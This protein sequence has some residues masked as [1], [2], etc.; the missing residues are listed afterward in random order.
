M[1]EDNT[2]SVFKKLAKKNEFELKNALIEP[3]HKEFPFGKNG[4]CA[5]IGGMGKG[6]SYQYLKLAHKQQDIFNQ[7]FFETVVICSTSG[8]FDK[9]VKSYKPAIEKSNLISVKDDELLEWLSAYKQKILL[10]NTIM[11]YVRNKFK[12]PSE[13]MIKIINEYRL[14]RNPKRLLKFINMKLEEIGWKTYPHRL[15]LILDDFASHPLLKHKENPLSRELKKLRHFNINVI[16]CVQTT[17]SI[18]KDIKRNLSDIVLFTG[19][20]EEDFKF[21][22]RESS[23]SCF[24]YKV[25]WESYRKIT[26]NHSMMKLHISARRVIIVNE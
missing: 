3:I 4:I 17:K 10:Y 8:E 19:I 7:P 13:D 21:L 6:K 16:I 2:D 14:Q 9:T 15:L 1:M 23:A 11:E 18:P 12:N 22:I 26:G 24:E 25:L 20:S 5:F